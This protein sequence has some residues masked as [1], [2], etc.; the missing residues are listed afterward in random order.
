MRKWRVTIAQDTAHE[1]ALDLGRLHCPTKTHYAR[2]SRDASLTFTQPPGRSS[3]LL[4]QA[5]LAA[6]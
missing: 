3:E 5:T 4:V 2:S 1:A 6:P